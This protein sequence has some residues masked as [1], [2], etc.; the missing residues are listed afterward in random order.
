MNAREFEVLVGEAMDSLPEEFRQR[1]DNIAITVADW[2]TRDELAR[3]G[4]RSPYGLLGLYQG[5]PLT[6]RGRGYNLIPPDRIVLYRRPILASADSPEAIRT[7]VQRVVIHE[8][9]HHFGI[10]DARLRE[11]GY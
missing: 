8:I 2:P 9:A 10:S 7:L 1:L 11:L 4:Q 3:T 5:V 6:Q